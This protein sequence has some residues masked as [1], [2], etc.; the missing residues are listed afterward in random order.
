MDLLKE[1]PFQDKSLYVYRELDAQIK[2]FKKIKFG[3][4]MQKIDKL[5]ITLIFYLGS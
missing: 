5:F 3:I 1:F 4:S 2:S